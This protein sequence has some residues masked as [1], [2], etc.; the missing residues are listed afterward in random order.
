[1][2][3]DGKFTATSAD[4]D[5]IEGEAKVSSVNSAGKLERVPHSV[6][7][8]INVDVDEN[9]EFIHPQDGKKYKVKI[10]DI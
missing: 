7:F 8:K 6:T 5:E 4:G 9:S 1:M 3:F 2:L 10:G